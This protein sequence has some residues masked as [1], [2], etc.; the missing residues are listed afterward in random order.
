MTIV[1]I[2]PIY[3]TRIDFQGLPSPPES[4]LT[5]SKN[6]IFW[7]ENKSSDSESNAIA[8]F[9]SPLEGENN[10]TK[11]ETKNILNVNVQITPVLVGR[12][13]ETNVH[14]GFLDGKTVAVKVCRNPKGDTRNEAE[15]LASLAQT[16]KRRF[17]VNFLGYDEMQRALVMEMY[18]HS[19]KSYVLDHPPI[20]QETFSNLTRDLL[21]G[22]DFLH[23]QGI[24]HGDLKPGNILLNADL[25]PVISDLSSHPSQLLTT[26]YAAPELL[27]HPAS[28]PNRGTDLYSLGMTLLFT[29]IRREPYSEL[30]NTLQKLIWVRRGEPA[31][32]ISDFPKGLQGWVIRSLI[33]KDIRHVILN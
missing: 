29:A 31:A 11:H 33:D 18:P 21:N 32:L 26:A 5:G 6:F 19:L 12:G 10:D 15:I 8:C 14:R 25:S 2:A 17:V 4:P 9:P 24:V 22:L 3:E 1:E 23:E 7:S 16:Y 30:K 28:A 27:S 20:S 13:G